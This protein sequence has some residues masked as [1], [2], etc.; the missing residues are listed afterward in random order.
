MLSPGTAGAAAAAAA[1]PATRPLW[2]RSSASGGGLCLD[3]GLCSNSSRRDTSP[4]VCAA[5]AELTRAGFARAASPRDPP[6]GS[7]GEG[8]S[9]CELRILALA[10]VAP[11]FVPANPAPIPG[12]APLA[13]ALCALRLAD[14]TRRNPFGVDITTN[15]SPPLSRSRRRLRRASSSSSS[16]SAS[17]DA[18][19]SAPNR[20]PSRLSATSSSVSW[21]AGPPL[22]R[23]TSC[24]SGPHESSSLSS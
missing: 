20:A 13:F 10:G 22:A 7:A 4:C 16:S 19:P 11:V 12:L 5:P 2:K 15:S 14:G 21:S 24:V 17:F 1:T 23:E 3:G 9:G 18:F 6:R 8:A